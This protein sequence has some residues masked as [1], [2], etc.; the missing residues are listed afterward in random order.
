MFNVKNYMCWKIVSV[1]GKKFEI[2]NYVHLIIPFA[3]EITFIGKLHY[4]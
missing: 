4:I 2:Q 3:H 1:G